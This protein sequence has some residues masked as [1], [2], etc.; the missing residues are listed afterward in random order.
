MRT[1]LKKSVF[2]A[3]AFLATSAFISCDSSAPKNENETVIVAENIP[4]VST[5]FKEFAVRGSVI[6]IAIGML[7]GSGVAPIAPSLINDIVM[8]PVG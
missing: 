8:P 1:F 2:I 3:I 6:D 4:Q 7:I 5:E